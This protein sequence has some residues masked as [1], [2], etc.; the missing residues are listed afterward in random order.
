LSAASLARLLAWLGS[1]EDLKKPGAHSFLTFYGFSITKDPHILYSKTSKVYLVTTV[2]KLSR[3]SLGFSP[4]WGIESNGRYL[5][6]KTSEFPRIGSVST[7]SAILEPNVD[8][9]YFLSEEQ[10][11]RILNLARLPHNERKQSLRD[12][13]T[14]TAA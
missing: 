10:S 8:D 12:T 1:V 5:T 2:E 11:D 13:S 4:T 7:L 3:Q 6:A 9:K 14:E